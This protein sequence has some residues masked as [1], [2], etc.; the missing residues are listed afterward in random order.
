MKKED[1]D[2]KISEIEDEID[3]YKNQI[4]IQKFRL[5]QLR[6]ERNKKYPPKIDWWEI[7]SQIP[8]W[9]GFHI[10]EYSS[11]SRT[12]IRCYRTEQAQYGCPDGEIIGYK[13]Y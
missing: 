2:F 11:H 7:F 6:H 8:C 4:R 3:E 5:S 10:W 1:Y 13:Q 9:F 12:C